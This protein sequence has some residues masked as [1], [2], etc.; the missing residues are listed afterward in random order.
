[1]NCRLSPIALVVL[2]CL[3]RGE[4]LS[5]VVA[6]RQNAKVGDPYRF[7]VW[8]TDNGLPQNSVLAILQ[9][10]D[11]YL[12]LATSDGL[13]RFDG[14]RFTVFNRSNTKGLNSNRFTALFEDRHG[15]LW[16][17]TDDR[18]LIRYRDGVF[19]PY[20]T[21]DGLPDYWVWAI[22]EDQDGRLLV[23]TQY[24]IAQWQGARFGPFTP[25][26]G[27]PR[28][29]SQWEQRFAG[30]SFYDAAGVHHFQGAGYRTYTM[31]DGLSSLDILSI[32]EDRHGALWVDTARAGLN[33][34]KDGVVTVYQTQ[35]QLKNARAVCEDHSGGLWIVADDGLSR[36]KDGQ[37]T[38]Y[39]AAAGL[40]SKGVITVYV[41]REGVAWLGTKSDG[42]YRARSVAVTAYSRQDGLAGN[43]VYAI[44]EDR[45]GA[46][47]IGTWDGGL[48]RYKDGAFSHYTTKD[49]LSSDLINALYEDREGALWVGT[50]D[51]GVNR[52]DKGRF[53]TFNKR[54]GLTDNTILAIYQ[55]RAG[56]L[57]FG[58]P[59][60]LNR[61]KDGS[62]T[63]YSTADGLVHRKVQAIHEDRAGNLWL[64]T[65]GGLSRLRDGKFTS[66]TEQD[67]LSSNHVRSIYEDSDGTLWV[68]T[69]DGGLNRLKDGRITAYTVREGLFNNGVFQILEDNRGN[70]W[71][72]CNQGIYRVSK[73]EL[74]DFAAGRIR[75]IISVAYGK[76]DGMLNSE[77]NGGR[78][79]AGVKARDGRLW[80][81]T[82]AGVAVVDPEAASMS[83][84]PPPVVIE[85]FIL[86]KEPVAL[87]REVRILPRKENLEIHYTGLSLIRPEHIRFKY[88]LEGLDHGLGRG[89]SPS[90]RLLLAC[91]AGPLHLYRDRRQQRR[92]VEHRRA[93]P[94]DRRGPAL[95]AHL[96]VSL[97]GAGGAGRRRGSGAPAAGRATEAGSCGAGGVLAAVDRV[98][99]ARAPKDRGG[100]ARQ[101]EPEY[102]HHQEPGRAELERARRSPAGLRAVGRNRRSGQ[103]RH[104]RGERDRIR[105][106]PLPPGP[107]RPDQGH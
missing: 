51:Q 34:L 89:R 38:S 4:A 74:N 48:S 80:F 106:A 11:G 17:G 61:Y 99:G 88:K 63:V 49:G 31:K 68:G 67:G 94:P 3:T 46:I 29:P 30:L 97:A 75:S 105:V 85:Q 73:K 1:M 81:P 70:L 76:S 53:T 55:D 2:L 100:T 8:T 107:A 98:A 32:Y 15:N 7:D 23:L 60:G 44:H 96:V 20:T 5:E 65:L 14:V 90:H 82:Q 41:D 37:L 12:W 78:Q 66:Y 92:R 93:P 18:G 104:R 24:G 95:L 102:G 56:N 50:H 58:T 69:Y 16:A 57:W 10:R 91:P 13:V 25:A 47:W 86:D 6:A 43:N 52:L 72:S 27:L 28:H 87:E 62:F 71:M 42:L 33:R 39:G 19:T 54:D 36:L 9:T 59:S 35:G 21:A 77:C 26:E 83:T 40:T 22:R 45:A 64:G 103:P 101:P 79:P 84:Q